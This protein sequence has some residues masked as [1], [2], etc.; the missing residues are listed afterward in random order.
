MLLKRRTVQRA[1]LV[2]VIPEGFHPDE[3]WCI[4]A[5]GQ[6]AGGWVAG[7][8]GWTHLAQLRCQ[9]HFRAQWQSVPAVSIFEALISSIPAGD[10]LM[11]VDR[12]ADRLCAAPRQAASWSSGNSCMASRSPGIRDWR[13]SVGFSHWRF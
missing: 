1:E 10:W 6:P 3:I 7:D 9:W 2:E 13:H 12:S 4:R 5:P 11:L 8:D